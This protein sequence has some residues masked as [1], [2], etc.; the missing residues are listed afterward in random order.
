MPKIVGCGK[1]L[2]SGDWIIERKGVVLCVDCSAKYHADW[3]VILPVGQVRE[4]VTTYCGQKA[5]E[6]QEEAK[7]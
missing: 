6:A 2:S 7:Q 4:G 1:L 5:S 3:R